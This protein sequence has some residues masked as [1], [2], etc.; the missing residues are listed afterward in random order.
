MNKKA[1]NPPKT[2]MAFN[3]GIAGHRVLPDADEEKLNAQIVSFFE[4]IKEVVNDCYTKTSR[5]HTAEKPVIRLL[6]MLAEGS[7]R[8]AANIA[9][10]AGFSLQC[11]LPL[12]LEEYKKDFET[13]ESKNEFTKLLDKADSIFEIEASSSNRNRAYQNGGQ[14]LLNH[15]DILLAIWDHKDSGKVG[16]TSDIVSLAQQQDIPVVWISSIAPH[17]ISIIYGDARKYEEA[18]FEKNITDIITRI[19]LPSPESALS[20]ETYFAE[21]QAKRSKARLYQHT[22][23]LFSYTKKKT[24]QTYT[25][26]DTND[27]Y[28]NH[29]YKHF[30][31]ADELAKRYSDLYRSC[32]IIRQLLPLLASLGLALGFYIGLFGGPYNPGPEIFKIISSIGFF[33]QAFCFVLIIMLSNAEKR[34]HWHKKFSDYR[35]L[36][37]MLRQMEYLAP[38][39]L[40][41]NGLRA[42]AY[43][44]T[45]NVSWINWHLRSIIREAGLPNAKIDAEMLKESV[46]YISNVTLGNQIAYHSDNIDKMA[47]IAKRINKYGLRIYYCGIIVFFLRFIAYSLTSGSALIILSGAEKDYITKFFNMLSMVIPLFSSFLFGVSSQEGFERVGQ[48]SMAMTEKLDIHKSVIQRGLSDYNAF[49]K[50]AQATAEIMLSE[51]A[52]WNT[53]FSTKKISKA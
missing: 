42:P 24:A 25:E 50:Y 8:I 19:L 7:D 21:D 31:S 5:L 39:G 14:V 47:L 15:S 20:P 35:S 9:L 37:E 1:Q 22:K 52:D 27:F 32:G 17:K 40:V 26:A 38:A 6:S 23:T 13:E 44:N 18:S 45:K 3:I 33:I 43:L 12:S 28:K 2:R 4:L 48:L 10:Q 51:F 49:I 11:P 53:F 34:Y 16:G 29:Y 30:H 41:I 46:D 36:A